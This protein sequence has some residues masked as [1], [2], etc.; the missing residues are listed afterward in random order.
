MNPA[1]DA[2]KRELPAGI[3]ARYAL[4]PGRVC[5]PNQQH[6]VLTSV[7]PPH[8]TRGFQHSFTELYVGETTAREDLCTIVAAALAGVPRAPVDDVVDFYTAALREADTSLLDSAGQKPQYRC[9]ALS[10]SVPAPPAAGFC[11]DTSWGSVA[12]RSAHRRGEAPKLSNILR[13]RGGVG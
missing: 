1:M 8:P 3:K 5:G 12:L 7:A 13:S 2:G 9:A 11:D 4:L 10:V 6:H